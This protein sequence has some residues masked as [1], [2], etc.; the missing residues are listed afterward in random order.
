MYAKE[1]KETEDPLNRILSRW[2]K[3]IDQSSRQKSEKIMC[4]N[5]R[6]KDKN[7]AVIT[8]QIR[9]LKRNTRYVLDVYVSKTGGRGEALS[10][11][12]EWVTTK[13]TC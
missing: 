3:C 6:F 8:E 9:G 11:Q 2:N 1:V 10:Y 7:K 5:V 12:S 13:D 4:R